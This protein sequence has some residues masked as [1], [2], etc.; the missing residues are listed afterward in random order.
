MLQNVPKPLHDLKSQC[1]S[2]RLLEGAADAKSLVWTTLGSPKMPLQFLGLD[3]EA[4]SSTPRGGLLTAYPVLGAGEGGCQ[5]D[6][7]RGGADCLSSSV[8]SRASRRGQPGGVTFCSRQPPWPPNLRTNFLFG[9]PTTSAA[10]SMPLVSV[11]YF[12]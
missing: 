11:R 5:F 6:A 2:N 9:T 4:A 10:T 12:L 3:R 7:A 8:H 1:R